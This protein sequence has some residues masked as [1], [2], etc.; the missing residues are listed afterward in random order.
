MEKRIKKN[1]LIGGLILLTVINLTGIGAMFFMRFHESVPAPHS[2]FQFMKFFD[3][4]LKLTETQKAK[5]RQSHREHRQN[6]APIMENL[7]QLRVDFLNEVAKTEPD[8]LVL[9]QIA[10]ELGKQHTK[11]KRLTIRHFM[12]MKN[13]CTAEQ[14][15]NLS[16]MFREMETL[17]GHQK[18]RKMRRHGRRNKNNF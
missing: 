13:T 9:E 15:K 10:V 17:K 16:K 14:Q 7:R 4:E 8:S 3:E 2:R 1:I 12:Q 18:K 6:A 11:L 5:F